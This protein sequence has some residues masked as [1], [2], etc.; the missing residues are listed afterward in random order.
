V[1]FARSLLK[2]VIAPR[3]EETLELVKDRLKASGAMIDPGAG[4]VLIGGASQLAGAR[5]VAARV[6]DRPVRLGRPRRIPHLADSASGPAFCA[7]AGVL[8]RAAFGPRE[9]GPKRP[10]AV[11]TLSVL[12]PNAN[13]VARAAAWLRDNL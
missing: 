9:A 11:R 1:V 12:D 10:G 7:A 2:G 5:E 13:V 8:Q 4:I 3:V 6:F